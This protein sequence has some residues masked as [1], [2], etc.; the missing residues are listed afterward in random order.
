M[1]YMYLFMELWTR[2]LV[3]LQYEYITFK[4]KYLN[5]YEEITENK[6]FSLSETLICMPPQTN[7]P[8]LHL[9]GFPC[10]FTG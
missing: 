7:P 2:N 9:N 5:Y 6:I 4:N 1:K 3:P 8:P 10:M